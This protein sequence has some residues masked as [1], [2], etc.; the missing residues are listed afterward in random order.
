MASGQNQSNSLTQAMCLSL[1]SSFSSAPAKSKNNCVF[2]IKNPISGKIKKLSAKIS[3][4]NFSFLNTFANIR[5]NENVLK[6]VSVWKDSSNST[7]TSTIQATVPEGHYTIDTLLA[8]LNTPGVCNDLQGGYYYGLGDYGDED[9]YPPF[10]QDD[11]FPQKLHFH[12][13]TGGTLGVLGT[14]SAGGAHQYQGFYLQVD[15]DTLPLMQTMGLVNYTNGSAQNLVP[16]P[17]TSYVGVGI[18]PTHNTTGAYYYGS[19]PTSIP[20]ISRAD[21]NLQMIYNLAGPTQITVTIPQFACEGGVRC[22]Y[23]GFAS[24]GTLALVPVTGAYGTQND[25]NPP[26]PLYLYVQDPFFTSLQ[27]V[28]RSAQTGTLVDFD[29]VNWTLNIRIEFEE[30]QA[31]PILSAHAAVD[32]PQGPSRKRLVSQLEP[33]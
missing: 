10:S 29:G 19:T 7:Q 2:D 26:E 31:T 16:I 5:V 24:S 22:S 30:L 21:S 12:P 14:W 32:T 28:I 11:Q 9:N 8:Y 18:S 4:L 27:V 23:D 15:S 33:V 13:P 6:I 1:S 17:G 3:L 25:Y 20:S